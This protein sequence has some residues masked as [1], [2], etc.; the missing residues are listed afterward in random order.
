MQF[1][2]ISVV[3]FAAEIIKALTPLPFPASIY[4]LIIMLLLL[5]TKIIKYESVKDA[6]NFLVGAMATMFI[7]AA[8]GIMNSFH[9]IKPVL[10]RFIIAILITNIVVFGCSGLVT[11]WIMR[12]KD[13]KARGGKSCE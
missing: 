3:V 6:G 5:S 11:Q 12:L 13:K 9:I 7:P 8:V 4:G 2:I 10:V 1:G